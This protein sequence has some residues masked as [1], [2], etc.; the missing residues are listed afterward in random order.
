MVRGFKRD[1]LNGENGNDED[2][3]I[4]RVRAGFPIIALLSFEYELVKYV[5]LLTN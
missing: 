3:M 4:N 2:V 1:D 5:V